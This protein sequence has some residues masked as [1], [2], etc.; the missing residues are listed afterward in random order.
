MKLSI[1]IHFEKSSPFCT[2]AVFVSV[3]E[4]LHQP[5]SLIH[6]SPHRK[7]VHGDL[8]QD[9]F[10]IDDEKSPETHSHKAFSLIHSGVHEFSEPHKLKRLEEKCTSMCAPGPPDRLRSPWK[11]GE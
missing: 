7:I 1:K 4:G 10:V 8:P 2:F 5:Q 6:R 9:A 3:L 11:S